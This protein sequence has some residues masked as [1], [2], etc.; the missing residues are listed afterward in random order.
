V[1]RVDLPEPPIDVGHVRDDEG[2]LAQ[3]DVHHTEVHTAHALSTHA[4]HADR[5]DVERSTVR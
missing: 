4:A 1:A 2:V 5:V 3:V